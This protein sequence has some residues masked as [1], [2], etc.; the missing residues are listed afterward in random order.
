MSALTTPPRA[1][2]VEALTPEQE[3]ELVGRLVDMEPL[4]D[5]ASAMGV[6]DAAAQ[7]SA[8][9]YGHPSWS[10]LYR[11]QKIL[12]REAIARAE[13]EVVEVPQSAPATPDGARLVM[14]P[15]H[16]LQPDPD[17]PRADATEDVEGLAQSIRMNGLQQPIV[18]RQ[19]ADVVDVDHPAVIVAGHRRYAALTSLGHVSAQVILRPEMDADDVLA[20]MLI[21]NS[22]RRDLDPISEARAIRRLMS[23]S[24]DLRSQEAVAAQLGRSQPWVGRRLALLELSLPVQE[25]VRAG[26]VRLEEAVQLSRVNSGRSRAPRAGGNSYHLGAG[27]ALSDR[28]R[29]RCSSN[30]H[31]AYRVG[32]V[33]CGE[34]WEA[35]IRAD[36]RAQIHTHSVAAG[37]CATCDRT[38]S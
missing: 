29:R 12:K 33:A 6:P 30:G 35:V 2:D 38:M 34:C 36:E 19:V 7:A 18:A 8:I 15:L 16:L 23:T 22:Q 10:A 20:A 5:A 13:L 31:K 26:E 1:M 37:V 11:S 4:P 3:L 28:A 21:E 25:K 17:N 24:P 32:K 9:E 27:H 14:M